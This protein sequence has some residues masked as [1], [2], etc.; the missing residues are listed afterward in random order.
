MKKILFYVIAILFI[1]SSSDMLL[2]SNSLS[3]SRIASVSSPATPSS[4]CLSINPAEVTV[5]GK[6]DVTMDVG[7]SL[8][9][10]D[11][12][13]DDLIGAEVTINDLCANYIVINSTTVNSSTLEMTA[14]VTVDGEAPASACSIEITSPTLDCSAAFSINSSS[15]PSGE[16]S[17]IKITPGSVNVGFGF[18]PRFSLITLTFGEDTNVPQIDLEDIEVEVADGVYV[19]QVTTIGTDQ[20]QVLMKFWGVEPGTYNINIDNCGSIPLVI[21]GR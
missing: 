11:L 3:L 9:I 1:L 2:A 4:N 10:S 16:C 15:V 17:I 12:T 20:I 19:L 7:L 14:S 6:T 5:D 21:K 8:D 13:E 18:L